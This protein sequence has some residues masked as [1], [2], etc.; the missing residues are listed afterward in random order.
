M[1]DGYVE[2]SKRGAPLKLTDTATVT[3][4]FSTAGQAKATST[5][6]AGVSDG[7]KG[8]VTV[9]ASGAT[10]TIDANAVT[11]A[12]MQAVSANVLLGNDAAGTAVE[13]ITCTAAGRAILDDADASAQRTTLG[14]G[15][16]AVA[17]TG[18]FAA[19]SHNHAA[20][21][22][23]SGTVDT[24]RLGSGT[25]NSTTYLRGDQTWA[26]PAGGSEAF[27]VGSVFISV[28]STNPGTLLGYGTW[29]AF[30]AGK[31][32]IGLDSGDT[33][34][35]TVEETGGAKTVASAG[36][37]AAPTLSGSTAAEAAHTHSV[38]SNVTVADHSSHTHTY[39]DVPNHVH[40][41][42]INSGTTGGSNGY[43]VDTSTNGSAA[44]AISTANPT[45]GVATGTTAGPSATLTH[46]P[47]NN[48]VTSAAGS[49]HSHAVG[50][51]AASAPA[52]TGSATSVVQPYIVAYFWKRT[53]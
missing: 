49:S 14:L 3:W 35:D 13:E 27:P 4:D 12:K 31:V 40:V 11:F 43:G 28:V 21:A 45:G 44:T 16:A 20:S 26:T 39:T 24:A 8:D 53:A 42:N 36:T 33:D 30:G 38:T 25:A 10:W 50:T 51:L 19:A 23:T 7:D 15:T 5:G 34:F 32:L 18:D 29:A 41:Q 47:T 37:V 6:G 2:S 9:S 1:A 52:F 22:I 46:T 17:A 48:A